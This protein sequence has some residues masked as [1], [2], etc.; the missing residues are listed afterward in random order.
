MTVSHAP[1]RIVFAGTPSFA[2]P[3][4]DAL[5][6]A[7]Y[8]LCAVYTQPDRPAGRGRQLRPSP[9]KARATGLMIRQPPSLRDPLAQQE[10]AELQPDLLIVVAY[11]LLLPPAVL[12]IPRLGCVNVHA[13]L[14]PRWR[15]AAPIQRAVLA[16]DPESGIS[17]MQMDEG[18]DTGP[19][20]DQA[21]CPL[22]PGMT[23]GELQDRLALMGAQT[24]V[25]LLPELAAGQLSA[26]PQDDALATYAGK[27]D[28]AEAQ[29]DWSQPATILERQVLAFNPWPVAWTPLGSQTLRIWQ[30]K[31]L[32]ESAQTPPG[33]VIWEN[34]EGIGVATGKG[35]LCMTEVQLPGKRP[36][37][38]AD[39]I[40]ARQLLGQRLGSV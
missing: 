17:I 15:G 14:L 18:L 40:H 26:Y 7:G 27:I 3:T 39:F 38:V 23:A 10:L 12:R 30:A 28:K 16:G 13:S 5:L 37:A 8:S 31:T 32:T 22:T 25:R 1:L 4:L 34:H 33:T 11:G 2:V 20:L 36:M 29:L 24:L 9:V 19:V 21:V 6:T 35:V